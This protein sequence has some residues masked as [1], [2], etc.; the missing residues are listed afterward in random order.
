M[1]SDIFENFNK[2]SINEHAVLITH[3]RKYF[4]LSTLTPRGIGENIY[5]SKSREYPAQ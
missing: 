5:C 4:M 2:R 3:C 1:P